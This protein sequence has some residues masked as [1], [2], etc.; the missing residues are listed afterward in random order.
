MQEKL[1]ADPEICTEINAMIAKDVTNYGIST[2][3]SFRSKTRSIGYVKTKRVRYQSYGQRSKSDE[4]MIKME[5]KEIKDEE[6][7]DQEKMKQRK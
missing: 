2:I 6:Q 1:K 7:T 5:I 4:S 3:G